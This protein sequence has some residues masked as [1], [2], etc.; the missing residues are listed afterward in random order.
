[1]SKNSIKNLKFSDVSD[2]FVNNKLSIHLVEDKNFSAKKELNEESSLN[3]RYDTIH[4]KQ[5]QTDILSGEST[6]LKV[7]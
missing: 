7:T 1:M 4:F 6:A 5:Y 3:I 2:W